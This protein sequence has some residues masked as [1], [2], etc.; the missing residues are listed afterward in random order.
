MSDISG[1]SSTSVVARAQNAQNAQALRL[2][3]SLPGAAPAVAT[4]DSLTLSKDSLEMLR[5][6]EASDAKTEQVQAA[7]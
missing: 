2:L 7:G 3:S 4:T 1:C 6:S 5:L